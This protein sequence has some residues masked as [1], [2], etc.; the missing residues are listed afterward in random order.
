MT[1]QEAKDIA[2]VLIAR[3]A[4]CFD[5]TAFDECNPELSETDQDKIIREI[6]IISQKMVE[7]ISKKLNVNFDYAFSSHEIV[8]LIM[9]ED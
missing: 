9:Y 8:E 3:T 6:E 7:R 2:T 4:V 5:G 1:K